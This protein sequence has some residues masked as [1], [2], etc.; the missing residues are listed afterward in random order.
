[1]NNV[2]PLPSSKINEILAG[3]MSSGDIRI[4]SV[5]TRARQL[6][7]EALQGE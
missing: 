5:S 1:M 4:G 6:I 7:L 3:A 2:I